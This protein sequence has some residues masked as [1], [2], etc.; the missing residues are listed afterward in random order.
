MGT[1]K[2]GY[3]N[4]L[5]ANYMYKMVEK[6]AINCK[7][8]KLTNVTFI[9]HDEDDKSIKVSFGLLDRVLLLFR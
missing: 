8:S 6:F 9:L 5:V 4:D 7:G 1:G 3:P 2:I